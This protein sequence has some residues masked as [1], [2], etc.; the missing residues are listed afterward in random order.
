M[1]DPRQRVIEDF[2]AVV[3]R[4]QM[5][6]RIVVRNDFAEAHEIRF[7]FLLHEIVFVRERPPDI[8]IRREPRDDVAQITVVRVR[9]HPI[10]AP[11][12]LV[13][14]MKQNDVRLDAELLQIERRAVRDAE[15]ISD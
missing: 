7:L 13:V 12:P 15:N 10:K 2:L 5:M 8:A 6:I 14:R 4:E 1:R 9:R 11:M 3:N